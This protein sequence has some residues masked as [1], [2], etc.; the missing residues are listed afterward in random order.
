MDIDDSVFEPRD[1][2][3]ADALHV[4]GEGDEVGAVAFEGVEEVS[5]KVRVRF[6]LHPADVERRYPV[7]PRRLQG[8]R[9]GVV[10][11]HAHDPGAP[12]A[13]F[14]DRL[15][16]RLEIGALPRGENGNLQVVGH[17]FLEIMRQI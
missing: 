16:D 7:L 5:V 8:A 9:S 2:G 3:R 17:I 4:P 1:D 11:H 15:Q 6:K 14:F 10:A 12:D 13:A